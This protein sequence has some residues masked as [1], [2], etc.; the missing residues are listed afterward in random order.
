M[1][2]KR[3]GERWRVQRVGEWEMEGAEGRRAGDG[4][5]EGGRAG[6]G[7]EDGGRGG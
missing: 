3:V 2:V 6:D 1:E 7:G 5:A 4:G